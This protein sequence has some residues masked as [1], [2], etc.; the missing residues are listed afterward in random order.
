[1]ELASIELTDIS[2]IIFLVFFVEI[3]FSKFFY[4]LVNKLE[5]LELRSFFVK[6]A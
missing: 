4:F 6:I 1:M 2:E 3:S 5:I